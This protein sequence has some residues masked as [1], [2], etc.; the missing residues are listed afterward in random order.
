[1][2]ILSFAT[3]FLVAGAAAA[4]ELPKTQLQIVGGL[5]NLTA[6]QQ[7]ERLCCKKSFE[8]RK[9]TDNFQRDF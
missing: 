9:S 6:Y 1:M 2:N 5:S 3:A 4:Q 8:G 7:F